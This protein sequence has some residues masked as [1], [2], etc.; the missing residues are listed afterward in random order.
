MIVYERGKRMGKR[1]LGLVLRDRWKHLMDQ[2]QERIDLR[3]K[4]GNPM[5][6]SKPCVTCN[7]P[8]PEYQLQPL[9]PYDGANE[10]D[11]VVVDFICLS[12]AVFETFS[13]QWSKAIDDGED[14]QRRVVREF[15]LSSLRCIDGLSLSNEVSLN[16]DNEEPSDNLLDVLEDNGLALGCFYAGMHVHSLTGSARKNCGALQLSTSPNMTAIS[17]TH[18]TELNDPAMEVS[19]TTGGKTSTMESTRRTDAREG[20]L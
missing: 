9:P 2:R 16:L 8:K 4:R 1:S 12:K 14:E 18:Q 10:L 17:A 7:L 13:S 11:N 20:R 3:I 15:L 19:G 5:N 6:D